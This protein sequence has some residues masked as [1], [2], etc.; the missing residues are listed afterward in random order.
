VPGKKKYPGKLM[1]E[2]EGQR[3]KMS[4]TRYNQQ[5]KRFKQKKGAE[6]ISEGYFF[7]SSRPPL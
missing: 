5:L 6:Y 3:R 1:R 4:Q 7:P 2:S